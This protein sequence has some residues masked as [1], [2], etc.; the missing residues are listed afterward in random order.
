MAYRRYKAILAIFVLSASVNAAASQINNTLKHFQDCDICSEMITLPEGNY[1]MGATRD[2]LGDDKKYKFIYINE[3]PRHYAHVKSFSIG[4]FSITKKQ[5]SVFARET[6]FIGKGCRTVEGHQWIFEENANWENPGFKQT[7]SDPVVCVSWNDTQKYIDWL[8]RKN[9]NKT[10]HQYRLPTEEEYEYAERA[11]TTT[12]AYWGNNSGDQCQHENTRDISAKILD[13]AIP[14]ASCDDKYVETAP[15]GSFKL[16]PWG[17]ADMLG[18]ALQWV[19]DCPRIGYVVS[20]QSPYS[21][22]V[23]CEM[24]GL[25][26]ASWASIPIAVRS[27]SRNAAKANV[28]NSTFGF[29]VAID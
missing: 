21:N 18:N 25:R 24:K 3:T 19:S 20:A 1:A 6:G 27:A 13:P 14:T 2:E 22:T 11:G 7:E 17:L 26:G 10:E 28:R 4:K 5:F 15:V 29:R 12:A 16:N 8:N 23:P 9:P